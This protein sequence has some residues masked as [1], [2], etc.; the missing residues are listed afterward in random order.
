MFFK[1]LKKK[2]SSSGKLDIPEELKESFV[3]PTVKPFNYGE[4]ALWHY[5]IILIFH[6]INN[7]P[8]NY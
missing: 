8:F 1:T 2:K 5:R 3:T 7:N 4:F 6:P